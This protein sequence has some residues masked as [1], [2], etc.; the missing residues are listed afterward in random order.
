MDDKT[1]KGN[2]SQGDYFYI[3]DV[4]YSD[5]T[6]FKQAMNGVQ[7]V[8]EL[9]TPQT[10]QLTPVEVK[11]LLGLNNVWADTGDVEVQYRADT[12]MYIDCK[13]TDFSK[14]IAP[15]EADYKA[16][17]AYT[18]GSLMIVGSQLYKATTSI[19]N[20]ATLTVGTNITATTL[21][22]VIAAL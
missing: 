2:R 5:A 3:R 19:A 18:S 10:Y 21:A 4:A 16:T 15:T 8:Y 11:T 6:T 9:A 14:L 1:C 12:K 20:G 22:E 13:N 17:R 7:L